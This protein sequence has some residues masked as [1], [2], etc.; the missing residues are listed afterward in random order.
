MEGGKRGAVMEN[1][2]KLKGLGGW[3]YLVGFGIVFSSL[4]VLMDLLTIYAPI[5]SDGSWEALT[6]V[7]SEV[8]IPFFA[9]LLL[10]EINFN[11]AL[12]LFSIYLI[13]LYFTKHH[14]FPKFYIGIVVV[15][16][17]FILL[18]AWLGTFLLPN[19][20]MFDP[21]TA[22][23]FGRVLGAGIIWVPYMLV[24]KRVK[25]TFI[26]KMPNNQRNGSAA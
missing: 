2:N 25:A 3:L 26:E 11:S 8:Y 18:D 15:N 20:P 7:G 5:F 9:P 13:Y 1:E 21:E 22:Q 16:A 23:E 10:V 14:L 12:F 4:R 17:I 19:E 24:S 6:T